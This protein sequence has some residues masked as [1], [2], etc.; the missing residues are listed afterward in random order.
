NKQT[1]QRYYWLTKPGIIYGNLLTAVGGFL[2]A[3]RGSVDL[4][5]LAAMAAGI[6]LVMASGCVFNNVMDRQLDAAMARTKKRAMVTGTISTRNALV[7]GAVL[8][9]AGLGMLVAWTTALAAVV[10]AVGWVAYVLVYGW[11]KRAGWYGT[12]VGSISGAVPPVVG[13]TA[14]TGTL[15]AGAWLVF[16]VLVCWQMPHFYAIA[17]FRLDDYKAAKVPVL[18]AVTSAGRTK[19]HI[20]GWI[21]AFMVAVA[22]LWVLGYAGWVYL[23]VMLALSLEWLRRALAGFGTPDDTKW[24]RGLFGFSLIVLTAW[25]VM[26]GTTAWLP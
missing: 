14:V 20:V 11:A 7:Y 26:I 22:L 24:A 10:A 6:A 3:A 15:D 19:E 13:Y 4:G 9:L 18:P 2:L 5:L 12:I 16:A 1:L 25:S 17:L 8:G 23:V 21:G